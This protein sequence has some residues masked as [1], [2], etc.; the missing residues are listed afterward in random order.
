M[1]QFRSQPIDYHDNE[2][3]L[4][5]PG[6]VQPEGVKV[7]GTWR[8]Y[9]DS[10]LVHTM[11][12]VD[13]SEEGFVDDSE[14]FCPSVTDGNVSNGDVTYFDSSE[15]E[16][17]SEDAESSSSDME[18]LDLSLFETPNKKRGAAKNMRSASVCPC[19]CRCPNPGP[20]PDCPEVC[21]EEQ[22]VC[23]LCC[24]Q[25]QKE[26]RVEG[27]LKRVFRAGVPPA[28]VHILNSTKLLTGE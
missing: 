23:S 7:R 24:V 28:N 8:D 9:L 21:E 5:I 2:G 6:S 15:F 14:G 10:D 22:T 1:D 3:I 20:S 18:G 17:F 16:P 25:C 11:E 4:R 26:R 12:I 19:A 27:T 13:D